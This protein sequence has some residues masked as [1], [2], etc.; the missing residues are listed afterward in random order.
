MT[1]VIEPIGLLQSLIA[2][3]SVSPTSNV[4]ITQSIADVLRALGFRCT[5]SDYVDDAGVTKS[6]L[7][8]T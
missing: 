4:A 2:F 8:V 3:A 5:F 7:I 6:N 1:S